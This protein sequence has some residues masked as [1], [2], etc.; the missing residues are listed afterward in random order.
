MFML[1]KPEDEPRKTIEDEKNR[2]VYFLKPVIKYV[3]FPV[4]VATLLNYIIP[5]MNILCWVVAFYFSASLVL[6]IR[7]NSKV[8]SIVK[9]AVAALLFS[10]S[11]IIIVLASFG[12]VITKNDKQTTQLPNGVVYPVFY[13]SGKMGDIGDIRIMPEIDSIGIKYTTQ[14][15]GPREDDWKYITDVNGN[16]ILNPDPAGF[17]GVMFLYPPNNIGNFKNGGLDISKFRKSIQWQARCLEGNVNVQ[18]LIGGVSWE[19]NGTEKDEVPYPDSMPRIPLGIKEL[20]P[21]W[22]IFSVDISS[23][24]EVNFLSVIDAF[25]FTIDWS[26][27]GVEPGEGHQNKTFTFEIKNIWLYPT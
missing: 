11:V 7:H 5:N 27:N 15:K 12:F 13:P 1:N 6:I 24:P 18:F 9:Y 19:W 14:G 26:S 10:Q 20:T 16:M 8:D 17:G 25:A 21:D 23:L 22:Q 3:V 2:L 4:I